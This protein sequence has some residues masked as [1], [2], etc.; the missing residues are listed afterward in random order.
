LCAG[1]ELSMARG[2]YDRGAILEIVGTF[3]DRARSV[4]TERELHSLMEDLCRELGFRYFALIHH[5]DLRN[6]HSGLINI[7]NYPPIWRDIWIEQ[8]LWRIDPVVHA[9]FRTCVGFRW[10]DLSMLIS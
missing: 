1:R 8:Q 3:I 6:A 4:T 7:N 9:C 10:S 2:R 5:A